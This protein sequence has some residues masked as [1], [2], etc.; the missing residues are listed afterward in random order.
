[1][2]GPARRSRHYSRLDGHPIGSGALGVSIALWPPRSR[3][4][5]LTSR[6]PVGRDTPV[7]TTALSPKEP[8]RKET[9][10]HSILATRK[11]TSLP[12]RAIEPRSAERMSFG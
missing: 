11:P 6:A 1:M 3:R 9:G 10:G 12:V 8:T 7:R 5:H 2:H 4:W